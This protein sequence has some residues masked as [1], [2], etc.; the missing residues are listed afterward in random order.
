[1][2]VRA[3][4]CGLQPAPSSHDFVT[5]FSLPAGILRTPYRLPMDEVRKEIFLFITNSI[6]YALTRM[7]SSETELVSI[8][9][10]I[11]QQQGHSDKVPRNL[12]A[13]AFDGTA[14]NEKIYPGYA[15]LCNVLCGGSAE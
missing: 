9:F 2:G 8:Y 3:N 12:F 14:I 6:N 4:S 11:C 15:A 10:G 5:F 7:N 1:V 13:A